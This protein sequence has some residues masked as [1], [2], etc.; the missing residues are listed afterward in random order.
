MIFDPQV[1]PFWHMS[2]NLEQHVSSN[3]PTIEKWKLSIHGWELVPTAP[4]LKDMSC[5]Q[6]WMYLTLNFS[7]RSRKFS[8]KQSLAT[9]L[10]DAVGW[11]RS[12]HCF[13]L[14]S[15]GPLPKKYGETIV[16]SELYTCIK[17]QHQKREF[18]R[19]I[20]DTSWRFA[21]M[22]KLGDCSLRSITGRIPIRHVS[23]ISFD[24]LGV[25][26][27]LDGRDG[28]TAPALKCHVFLRISRSGNTHRKDIKS[29]PPELLLQ[30]KR[31]STVCR[32]GDLF[33]EWLS[34][35]EWRHRFPASSVFFERLFIGLQRT[36]DLKPQSPVAAKTCL[37]QLN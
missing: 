16:P 15:F 17:M 6:T 32:F 4:A 35:K 11:Q 37:L 2:L 28:C 7:K 30:P 14:S 12:S 36:V 8:L 13:G 33:S 5:F 21:Q 19:R 9:L 18:A 22:L 24:L 1:I 23:S 27:L 25:F 34:R 31:S 20:K 26:I 10:M 3:F 29:T